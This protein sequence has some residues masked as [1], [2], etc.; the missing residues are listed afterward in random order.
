MT[1]TPSHLL[2]GL[3]AGAL[4]LIAFTFTRE[5]AA[6][7]DGYAATV[8]HVQIQHGMGSAAWSPEDA[9]HAA[10][11]GARINAL[12]PAGASL[13]VW[14]GETTCTSASGA[15][16]SVSTI[17]V[18]AADLPQL[19]RA[20][21]RAFAVGPRR[22]RAARALDPRL[23]TVQLFSGSA[24]GAGALKKR[25]VDAGSG[26][27]GFFEQGGFPAF[28]EQAHV[29]HAAGSA[30]PYRVVTG[31]FLSRKEAEA[32]RAALRGGGFS[33]FVRELPPGLAIGE[34]S[35]GGA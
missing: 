30:E 24:R 18:G 15:C 9:R 4:A 5:A 20:V 35:S 2:R 6:C 13:D 32:A 31:I 26:A 25:I 22:I 27:H 10:R 12:L 29:L 17:A 16:G 11:W 23:F 21:A 14:T 7:W 33:G 3:V 19:F 28:N 8:G 34:R 1:H